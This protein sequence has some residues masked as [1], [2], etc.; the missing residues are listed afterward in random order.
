[1]LATL[2]ISVMVWTG[3]L[4]L[5][6]QANSEGVEELSPVD[7][8][9]P[10]QQNAPAEQT[11]PA[12]S[13][14]SAKPKV[15]TTPSSDST[16]PEATSASKSD[17]SASTSN[18]PKPTNTGQEG[19][20]RPFQDDILKSL[21][22]DREAAQTIPRQDPGMPAQPRAIIGSQH[23]VAG[24]FPD[25]TPIVERPGRFYRNG[26]QKLMELRLAGGDR[27]L[28]LELLPNALLEALEREAS[29]GVAE[30]TISGELTRYGNKNYLILRKVI[31]RVDNGNLSP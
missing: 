2:V 20:R 14:E 5:A 15:S 12:E 21:L 26:D 24:V 27:R 6:M 18:Q 9:Q 10:A 31:Q 22:R 13:A 7:Q 1:M 3:P 16:S 11:K 17:A 4:L 23:E 19:I 28:S 29:T 25:G 8:A 30:F